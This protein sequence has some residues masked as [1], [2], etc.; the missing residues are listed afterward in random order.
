M[1]NFSLI[2]LSRKPILR[3]RK[4]P[5][6]ELQ[7]RAKAPSASQRKQSPEY[8]Y[9]VI[10]AIYTPNYHLHTATL[11]ISV[12]IASKKLVFSFFPNRI[13][14]CRMPRSRSILDLLSHP[15]TAVEV[16]FYNLRPIDDLIGP[17]L[18]ENKERMYL[19]G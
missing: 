9:S 6:I 14:V 7:V 2:Y 15:L 11:R 5:S 12:G 13:H 16:V 1:F 17:V 8:Y 4:S 19:P 18:M 3:M 10:H